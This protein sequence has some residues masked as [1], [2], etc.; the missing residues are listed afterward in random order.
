MRRGAKSFA[1]VFLRHSG[2]AHV[3]IEPLLTTLAP[4][5]SSNSLRASSRRSGPIHIR[6]AR[7]H[8][9]DNTRGRWR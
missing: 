5:M 8:P 1:V 9:D 4:K 6:R 7:Q 3:C 2:L